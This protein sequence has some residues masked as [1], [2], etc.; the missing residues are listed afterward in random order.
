MVKYYIGLLLLITSC[1][2]AD[3]SFHH[4]RELIIRDPGFEGKVVFERLTKTNGFR[5]LLKNSA[6]ETLDQTVFRYTA[7]QLDTADVD[8]NGSTDVLVGLIK[9]TEFDRQEKKR[10]FILRIDEGQLRPLWLGSKVCQEL[11]DFK[12]QADGVIRTLEKNKNNNYALGRYEWQ[13]F[14]LALI[15]YTHNEISFDEA[16][17]IFES[18]N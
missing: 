2:Q 5:L 7:Y 3:H 15:T 4:Q 12:S 1:H 16:L 14:G 17:Q 13:S 11:I 9:S 6:G 18:R 10:L 8:H